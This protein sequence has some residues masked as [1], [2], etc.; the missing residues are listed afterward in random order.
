MDPFALL[1][2]LDGTGDGVVSPY[3]VHRA[4]DVVRRGAHGETHA[5]LEAVLGADEAP[6][7]A[8]EGLA[9]AQAASSRASQHLLHGH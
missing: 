7:V 9:L 2:R 5:A 8:A 1:D 3:G 4:L 6:E